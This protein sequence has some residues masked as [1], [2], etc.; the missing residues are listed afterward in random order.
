VSISCGPDIGAETD[1]EI[2]TYFVSFYVA[3]NSDKLSER[4]LGASRLQRDF[5]I[6][7]NP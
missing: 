2:F 3:T 1:E 5:F 4:V 6:V 7:T